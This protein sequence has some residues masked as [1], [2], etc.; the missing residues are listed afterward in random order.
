MQHCTKHGWRSTHIIKNMGVAATLVH[1]E[2]LQGGGERQDEEFH[3]LRH[4]FMAEVRGVV[5]QLRIVNLDD[6]TPPPLELQAA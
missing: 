4:G 6:E 3:E 2:V 1:L 5:P